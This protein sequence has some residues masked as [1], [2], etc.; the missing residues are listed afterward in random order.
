MAAVYYGRRSVGEFSQC[1]RQAVAIST[2]RA[3]LMRASACRGW[4]A[5]SRTALIISR[6]RKSS[7][8]SGEVL[9]SGIIPLVGGR[10]SMPTTAETF[11]WAMVSAQLPGGQQL[12][13][14]GCSQV[15]LGLWTAQ[16]CSCDRP[17]RRRRSTKRGSERSGSNAVQNFS[18]VM[19]EEFS[20]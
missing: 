16:S 8:S 4:L 17:T 20:A 2:D 10:D 19:N 1:G 6:S 3:K 13:Q 7:E 5:S 18:E 14:N 15:T 11:F 9:A 12:V